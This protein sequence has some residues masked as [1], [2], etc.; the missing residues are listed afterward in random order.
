M[1]GYYTSGEEEQLTFARLFSQAA[2]NA[3][4][5]YA[6]RPFFEASSSCWVP[7]PEN[8]DRQRFMSLEQNDPIYLEHSP[9][10]T[11]SITRRNRLMLDSFE[12]DNI[13]LLVV[14]GSIEV[15]ALARVSSV[16]YAYVKRLGHRNDLEHHAAYEGA[17]FLMAFYP[18][19]FEPPTTPLWVRQKTL[20]F[21]FLCLYCQQDHLLRSQNQSNEL[22]RKF[23]I[24]LLTVLPHSS[25]QTVG[26]ETLSR[27][28]TH[29][30]EHR[31]LVFGRSGAHVD[32]ARIQY[33]KM[34]HDDLGGY[35]HAS[36]YVAGPP[37]LLNI[38]RALSFRKYFIPLIVDHKF[39]EAVAL[40]KMVISRGLAFSPDDFSDEAA[41]APEP[42]LFPDVEAPCGEGP[43]I[44]VQWAENLGYDVSKMR[45]D[46][47]R[48]GNIANIKSKMDQTTGKR[49]VKLPVKQAIITN[50]NSDLKSILGRN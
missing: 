20:Y 40:K 6:P 33:P 42:K 47:Q 45:E 21:G 16:H 35:L 25:G 14:D 30:P 27:L 23:E 48:Y 1:I 18:E 31:L 22:L 4:K 36:S 3:Y 5:V 41:S 13:R 17:S 43:G 38:A 29:F 11:K 34:A 46:I 44:F 12:D 49:K 24:K 26:R 8:P 19:S 28:L 50:I 2:P 15:A 9:P 37:T 32:S 10:G 39:R 7:I